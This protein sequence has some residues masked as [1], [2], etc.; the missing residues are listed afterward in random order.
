MN[1]HARDPV[2]FHCTDPVTTDGELEPFLDLPAELRIAIYRQIIDNATMPIFTVRGKC[3]SI[4]ET[5]MPTSYDL[6]KYSRIILSWKQIKL[7]IEHE[8]ADIFSLH[9]QTIIYSFNIFQ[10]PKTTEFGD[11]MPM[12][13]GVKTPEGQ[14]TQALRVELHRIETRFCNNFPFIVFYSMENTDRLQMD[15]VSSEYSLLV[16]RLDNYLIQVANAYM[17]GKDDKKDDKSLSTGS[18]WKS[19]V[20]GRMQKNNYLGHITWRKR[21]T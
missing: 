6:V 2:H 14:W 4:A 3:H 15:P 16:N 19:V 7:E 1:D 11:S 9:T 20:K 13:V 18:A 5:R 10:A 12:Q 17:L 21:K 8:W